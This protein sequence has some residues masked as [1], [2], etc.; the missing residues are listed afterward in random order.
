MA[1]LLVKPKGKHGK[2]HD[3]TPQSA[4]W[5]YVGFTLYRLAPGESASEATGDREAILVLVEGR[6]ELSAGGV[7]FGERGERLSVFERKPP[8]CLYVPNGLTWEAKA[9]TELTLAVCTAPGSGGH[10]A[11]MI[12]DI[13]F[14][15]RGIP[16]N[17]R[18]A[19]LRRLLPRPILDHVGHEHLIAVHPPPTEEEG[20]DRPRVTY[21][22][23]SETVIL[24]V[25]GRPV[26]RN[27]RG[28]RAGAA[29]QASGG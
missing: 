24:A 10:E 19:G 25:R 12:E 22:R 3:I 7:S 1:D 5:S 15:E 23:A 8:H 16:A 11:G 20:Q 9:T 4:G 29:N 26:D 14:E 17:V 18:G 2:V 13:G 28:T 27:R 21:K 6:A